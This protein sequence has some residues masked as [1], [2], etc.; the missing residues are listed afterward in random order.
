M[1]IFNLREQRRKE[2]AKLEKERMIRRYDAECRTPITRKATIEEMNKIG[3]K[4][5]GKEHITFLKNSIGYY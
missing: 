2:I 1:P 5:N 4:T 3:R